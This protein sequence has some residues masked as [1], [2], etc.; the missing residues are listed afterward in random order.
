M[1]VLNSAPRSIPRSRHALGGHVETV[2]VQ[3][4]RGI[5]KFHHVEPSF[6]DFVARD[7][8]LRL[9]ESGRNRFLA[10]PLI[11]P[12]ADELF[13]HPAIAIIVNSPC[14]TPSHRNHVT[15]VERG[16]DHINLM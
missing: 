11:L 1:P 13:D 16:H 14:H 3:G 9:A 6:A 15:T 7:I 10:K 8:L 2:H 4:F 5:E 12:R